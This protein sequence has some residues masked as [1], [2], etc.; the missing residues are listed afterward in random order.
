MDSS[1]EDTFDESNATEDEEEIDEIFEDDEIDEDNQSSMSLDQDETNEAES[2]A[3]HFMEDNW[4][5]Q[6]IPMAVPDKSNKKK[7]GIIFLSSIPP[8]FNVSTSIA[9]FSQFGKIGRV[10][11]Q[12][13]KRKRNFKLCRSDQNQIPTI[14]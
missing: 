3:D 2:A 10:F 13:G 6:N 11:L 9:F 12:P 8:G 7:P 14:L 1:D 4:P 5:P